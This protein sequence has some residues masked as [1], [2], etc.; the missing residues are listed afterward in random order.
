MV[1]STTPSPLV[2]IPHGDFEKQVFQRLDEALASGFIKQ[3]K[4]QELRSELQWVLPFQQEQFMVHLND[5][6]RDASP[7][8]ISKPNVRP[9]ATSFTTQTAGTVHVTD[10][11]DLYNTD[12]W[13]NDKFNSSVPIPTSSPSAPHTITPP[14]SVPAAIQ[15]P[16]T[17]KLSAH[18]HV[19]GN[20]IP[21][22]DLAATSSL[23]RTDTRNMAQPASSD[24]LNQQRRFELDT[25]TTKISAHDHVYSDSIPYRD[26][27]ATP[28]PFQIN[29][30]DL[31]QS[32]SSDLLNQHTSHFKNIHGK[33]HQHI[34]FGKHHFTLP[35]VPPP[36]AAGNNNKPIHSQGIEDAEKLTDLCSNIQTRGSENQIRSNVTSNLV[37]EPAAQTT[38][39]HFTVQFDGSLLAEAIS[40]SAELHPSQSL[41]FNPHCD[42]K[43]ISEFVSQFDTFSPSSADVKFNFILLQL[44]LQLQLRFPPYSLS[45]IIQS[46]FDAIPDIEPEPPPDSWTTYPCSEF[47]IIV[48]FRISLWGSNSMSASFLEF[49]FTHELVSFSVCSITST[50]MPDA[51]L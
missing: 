43:S 11:S 30:N 29:T 3:D 8:L 9:S 51:M 18:H 33:L 28:P 2:I 15:T 37:A 27:P 13:W 6:I 38:N 19:Y 35:P 23:S 50:N 45:N 44:Q 10:D 21:C 16:M 24:L 39:K 48:R 1:Q 46:P 42:N 34:T 4:Y 7:T 41:L 26:L 40:S 20:S 12:N 47:I 36:P 22:R 32:A 5:Q 49:S 14:T 17:T 25:K 31:A